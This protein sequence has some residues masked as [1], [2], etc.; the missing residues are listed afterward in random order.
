MNGIFAAKRPSGGHLRVFFRRT[1]LALAT[2]AAACMLVDVAQAGSLFESLFG[3]APQVSYASPDERPDAA[4]RSSALGTIK[5]EIPTAAA[6]PGRAFCVRLCDGRY[7]PIASAAANS[8]PVEMCS[9][10][11][12]AAKTKVFRGSE[13]AGATDH[14]GA[15][16]SRLEQAFAYRKSVVPGCSCNGKDAYGLV[17]VDVAADPTLRSGDIVA[18]VDGLRPYNSSRSVKAT[19]PASEH[20]SALS[21]RP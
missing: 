9:A 5:T 6:T 15:R 19:S 1:L 16:Y 2:G 12:P 14:A 21:N 11:C 8:T 4:V 18:T 17:S 20:I 7:Y 3:I 13:I 10:M